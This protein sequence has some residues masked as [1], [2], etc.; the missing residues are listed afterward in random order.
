MRIVRVEKLGP[1]RLGH[2]VALS[3]AVL[4]ALSVL[5]GG[6]SLPLAVLGGAVIGLPLAS[7]LYLLLV[8]GELGRR[9]TVER[10][11]GAT[12]VEGYA[13]P[14]VVEALSRS[15][16]V[17]V[18]VEMEDTPPRGVPLLTEPRGG[19]LLLPWGR[20]T[21]SYMVSPRIGRWR[22]G[23]LRLRLYDPL[24]LAEARMLVEPD[25]EAS[26]GGVPSRVYMGLGG[27]LRDIEDP[28]STPTRRLIQREGTEI[29]AIREWSEGDELRLIDWKATA[30]LGKLYVKELRRETTIPVLLV[31]TPSPLSLEGEPYRTPFEALARA[32]YEIGEAILAKEGSVG[33]LGITGCDRIAEPPGRGSEGL[34][35]LMHA[36][37]M[38]C[39]P[40]RDPGPVLGAVVEYLRKHAPGRIVVVIASD[41]ARAR[42]LAREMQPLAERGYKI[43][44][45]VHTGEGIVLTAHAPLAP[46]GEAR[47]EAAGG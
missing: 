1:T 21:V 5:R 22:F 9:I 46:A 4:L 6:G 47:A 40:E 36:I 18:L 11:V 44:Y 35:R 42:E 34:S 8:A 14:V 31:L 17:S 19:G 33:Y 30:R 20:L 12:P 15:K 25:G 39:P 28:Y 23:L 27:R 24:G 2:L 43:H 10:H 3:G 29:Y 13:S 45:L 37:S 41:E 32:V 16:L 26:V 7:Y 38:T